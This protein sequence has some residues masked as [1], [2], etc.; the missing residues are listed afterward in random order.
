[1]VL[2][3][4]FDQWDYSKK[5]LGE[6]LLQIALNN[7][8][9]AKVGLLIGEEP[10]PFFYSKVFSR[11]QVLVEEGELTPTQQNMQAQSLMDINTA[12]GREVFPPSMIVPHMNITGKAEAIQYLQQQEQMAQAQQQELTNI[13]HTFEEAKLKELYSKAAANIARAREDHSRSESNLGLYEE[14]LS[15]IERNRAM[16]LKDKQE[17]LTKLL[18]N[19]TRFGEIETQLKQ[20]ELETLNFEQVIGEE[21]EKRDVEMRT[22]ANKFLAEIMGSGGA[23]QQENQPQV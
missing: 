7:W 2:Q 15:M 23:S 10:S 4:Y 5:L 22:G 8:N 11:F 16:S 6:R 12:F 3:K 17:A 13:Q 1:M 20:N 21:R 18:E 14:R 9:A 19:V